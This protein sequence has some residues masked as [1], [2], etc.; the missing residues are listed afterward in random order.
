MN[1]A[2]LMHPTTLASL[3]IGIAGAGRYSLDA[4][5]DLPPRFLRRVSAVSP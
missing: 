1:R 4:S 3:A 2:S 5:L